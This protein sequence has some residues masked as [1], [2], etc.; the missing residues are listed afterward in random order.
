M[1]KFDSCKRVEYSLNNNILSFG[2]PAK[3]KEETRRRIE[4]LAPGGGF[5][6][7][8]IHIIQ[9][10]VPTQNL[11]AWRETLQEYGIYN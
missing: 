1:E 4:D 5:I 2:K 11:M 6:F 9:S 8:P 10:S 3:V 7:A